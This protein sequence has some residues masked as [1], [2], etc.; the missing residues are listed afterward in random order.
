MDRRWLMMVT[1]TKKNDAV[2]VK[3]NAEVNTNTMY[4]G[5]RYL[6]GICIAVFVFGLLWEGTEI[7]KLTLPQFLM[8]YG[9]AGAVISELMARFTLGRI[10]KK[11][12][13]KV[14]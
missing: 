10:K 3:V 4:V 1:E 8:V 6:E 12:S 13:E 14:E 11:T 5:I 2:E 7:L 9:G